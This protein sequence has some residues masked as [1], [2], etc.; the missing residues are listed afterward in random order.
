MRAGERHF[1]LSIFAELLRKREGFQPSS[2]DTI[3]SRDWSWL[4]PAIDPAR[5]CLRLAPL[6]RQ[7]DVQ[8]I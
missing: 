7:P 2:D 4:L 8:A 5:F 3:A 6:K 1:A